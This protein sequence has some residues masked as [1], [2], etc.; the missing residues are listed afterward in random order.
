[1][2]FRIRSSLKWLQCSHPGVFCSG[3]GGI[4]IRWDLRSYDRAEVAMG[5]ITNLVWWIGISP[6][7]GALISAYCLFRSLVEG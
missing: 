7:A 6:Y 4:A 3:L 2:G 1:M 5:L